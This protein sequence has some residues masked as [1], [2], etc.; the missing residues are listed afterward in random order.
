MFEARRKK[1]LV[2]CIKN[3]EKLPKGYSASLYNSLILPTFIECLQENNL[4]SARKILALC[5]NKNT[6]L[7]QQLFDHIT[8]YF[9]PAP[10]TLS[11]LAP[12]P[13]KNN[14]IIQFFINIYQWIFGPEVDHQAEKL[15]LMQNK[16]ANASMQNQYNL[17]YAEFITHYKTDTAPSLDHYIDCI[18]NADESFI[19]NEAQN[20]LAAKI[21]TELTSKTLEPQT[22][23]TIEAAINNISEEHPTTTGTIST[24]K[25][26]R[27][28]IKANTKKQKR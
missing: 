12:A 20:K 25:R 9:L 7:E 15:A 19:P 10:T 17:L 3:G 6:K 4:E 22:P 24:S 21:K 23:V 13:S 16:S 1:Y 14:F 8:L 26:S 2:A 27:K 28:I 18:L 11:T 5:K